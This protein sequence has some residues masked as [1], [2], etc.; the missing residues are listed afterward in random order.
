[1]KLLNHIILIVLLGLSTMANAELK[2]SLFELTVKPEQQQAI[3]EVG[4]HNLGTSIQT[5]NGTL[6]MF[7]TV[8]KD[9]PSKNVILEVYQDNEAYQTHTNAEHFK[10]FVAVAKS[11]VT[12]RKVE[13]LDSQILLEKRPLADFGNGHFLINLAEVRVKS[14]QNN[15]FKA[16]VLDEMKQSIAKE[17]G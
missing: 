17:Q 1:M 3:D 5:E 7:H 11:A 8:Q 12:D 16:I 10:Q 6:A 14:A 15:A 9:D 2:M 4:K 13:P